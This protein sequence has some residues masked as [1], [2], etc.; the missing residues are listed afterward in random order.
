MEETVSIAWCDN[1]M[2]DGKFMQG[3]TDNERLQLTTGMIT[4]SLTG[5]YG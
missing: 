2:V 4:I 1:G 5:Y 3:V